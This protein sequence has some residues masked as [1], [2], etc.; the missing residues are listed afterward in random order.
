MSETNDKVNTNTGATD[1]QI[2]ILTERI[3]SINTHLKGNKKDNSS[4]RGLLLLVSKR[5]KLLKYFKRKNL[6]GYKT[7]INKL[8]IRK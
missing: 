1:S 2:S 6:E 3:E 8:N 5:R 4:R 7:L